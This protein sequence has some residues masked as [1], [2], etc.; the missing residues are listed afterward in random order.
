MAG[1]RR[2][3]PALDV[4]QWKALSDLIRVGEGLYRGPHWEIDFTAHYRETIEYLAERG[5]V[6]VEDIGA[7]RFVRPTDKG[8]ERASKSRDWREEC[9]P[10]F[11]PPSSL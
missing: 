3:P 5:F 4:G 11:A 2:H 6:E 1:Y 9:W 10:G 8:R 7:S